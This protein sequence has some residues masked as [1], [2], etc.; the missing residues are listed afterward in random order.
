[1]ST[2]TMGTTTSLLT[3]E[4][5]RPHTLMEFNHISLNNVKLTNKQK[6][7]NTD[8]VYDT[9]FFIGLPSI[10]INKQYL[11]KIVSSFEKSFK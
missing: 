10:K 7:P 2:D 1:M 5:C 8:L 3:C 6:F 9:S 4:E 11:K